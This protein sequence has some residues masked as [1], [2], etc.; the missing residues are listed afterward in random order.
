MRKV[1]IIGLLAV[2]AIALFA[3]VGPVL[4]QEPPANP[5][6]Q[7][8]SVET[9]ARTAIQEAGCRP[10]P[11]GAWLAGVCDTKE[12][13]DALHARFRQLGRPT[14]GTNCSFRPGSTEPLYCDTR[15]Q[16]LSR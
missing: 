12:Q 10:E 7:S 14:W 3:T 5:P 15:A 6:A 2:M 11:H 1:I 9:R 8:A 4:A 13:T 16:V